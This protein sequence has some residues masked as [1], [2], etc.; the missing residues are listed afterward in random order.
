MRKIPIAEAEAG[1]VV[2]K[3][4]VTSAGVV[5]V[6]P[7]TAL[8]P[9]LVQRLNGLS[10][11]ALWVEGH[12]PNAKPVEQALIE[13]EQR[14]VGHEGNRLMMDLKEIVAARLRQ[15]AGEPDGQG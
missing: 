15:A 9:E 1:Q 6:Q 14:F 12:D 13:L 11:D 8:T 2:S 10:V 5:L 7:G 4:I 3:P